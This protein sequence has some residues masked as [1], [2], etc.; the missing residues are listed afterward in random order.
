[1]KTRIFLISILI[2]ITF[3]CFAQIDLNIYLNK[4]TVES[5]RTHVDTLASE[6]MEG[7]NTGEPGQKLAAR[8]IANEFYKYG[9]KPY[10]PDSENPYYQKF[11]LYKYQTGESKIYYN[12]LVYRVPIYFGNRSILDS[13]SGKIIFAGFAN[14]NDLANLDIDNKSIFFLSE[15]V[16]N[17]IDKAKTISN[18]YSVNTFVVGLPFGKEL[19]EKKFEE[20][21][22]DIKS[23]RELFYYYH[24][25]VTNHRNKNDFNKLLDQ[26]KLIPN[27][28]IESEKNIKILFVPENLAAG[29]FIK[30]FKELKKITKSNKKSGKN[31]L[32]SVIPADFSYEVYFDPRI[33]SLKTENIIGYIDSDLSNENVII[34]AHYDHIGRNYN[35]E[36]N[37]GAD[38]NASGTTGILSIAELI[39]QA[40]EDGIKLKKD[41][42]F[43]AYSAEE[44]GLHGS[45][46][47]VQNPLFPLSK[48]KVLFNLDMI[49]RDMDDDP[50]NSN[51]VF[52]L[53]WEGGAKYIKNVEKLN[54]EYTNL[55]VD[56]SPGMKNRILW[57]FGSDHYS[58]VKNGISSVAY[59]TALHDDYHTP[60][61][62]PDKLNYNKM[63][64]IIKLVFLN[65]WDL[66]YMDN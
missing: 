28:K 6:N 32:R 40:S 22:T 20:V 7:R 11:N 36:I 56:K 52:L 46:Y 27:L 33:D 18:S 9:L 10:K 12:K 62:T 61:D 3:V 15:S 35:Y 48:T 53:E 50:E 43:I 29:L 54:K 14:K 47:Y 60:R 23:F 42:I 34:G 41:I 58:Y 5:I 26:N 4:I 30:D 13:I 55:I 37:Y 66:T 59:F 31:N 16:K 45:D 2:S 51:R 64:R 65:I 39:S 24:Y 8:Y 25:F 57:T 63:N 49:G 44:L 38:D 17:A 21:I 19:D 1:M